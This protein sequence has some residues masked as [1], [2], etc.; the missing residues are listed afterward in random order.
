[1]TTPAT[2]EAAREELNRERWE[3]LYELESWLETPMIVLGFVWLVL[4]VVEVIWGLSPILANLGTVIWVIFIVDFLIRFTLA[5]KKGNY[6][7]H[8][9]LTAIALAV[10]AL[11]I[12]RIARVVRLLQLTR[13]TRSL[14]LLR[15][16]T[17]L[18]RG[19]K[20][21]GKTM[22]RRG[23]GYVAALTLIVVLVGAAG[24]LAFENGEVAARISGI[25]DY[26]TALWWTAMALTTVGT[27]YSPKSP[28]GRVLAFLISVYAL[29]VF[30]YITA[31]LATF[32][33][34][35]DAANEEGEVA[36]EQSVLALRGEITALR[37]EVSAMREGLRKAGDLD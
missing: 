23:V 37:Q 4:F 8:N 27:D 21:L 5:P 30:G 35:R 29:A 17:S 6:L 15:I 31:S 13:A 28:E 20:A 25:H 22:G 11:R 9:W 14:Q 18:N 19:M 1:M 24:I 16:L 26:G 12:F 3:I 33:I 34:G 36:G 7:K 32:F 10:P 2:K